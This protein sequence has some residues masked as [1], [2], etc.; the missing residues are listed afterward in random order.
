VSICAEQ[1]EP[2]GA[3]DIERRRMSALL[4]LAEKLAD[5]LT[6][7]LSR[8]KPAAARIHIGAL[9]AGW[10]NGRESVCARDTNE[11]FAISG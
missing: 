1:H 8:G 2:I 3:S 11:G 7:L 4:D 5:D 10:F 9:V 6:A